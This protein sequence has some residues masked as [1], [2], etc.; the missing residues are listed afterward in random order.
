MSSRF[1]AAAVTT[2][3]CVPVA[4]PPPVKAAVSKPSGRTAGRTAGR[5]G[6]ISVLRLVAKSTVP[7]ADVAA[8]A[9]PRSL[10]V[11][12]RGWSDSGRSGAPAE[13]E[14]EAVG[15]RGGRA[16]EAVKV[17]GFRSW[18]RS[19]LEPVGLETKHTASAMRTELCGDFAAW[20]WDQRIATNTLAAMVPPIIP[21]TGS[22]N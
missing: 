15:W 18:P 2:A 11:A 21:R 12:V 10:S 19:R 1:C 16:P 8:A 6:V 20:S 17:R 4:V 22:P 5:I 14:I 7:V 9:Q 3:G 13:F